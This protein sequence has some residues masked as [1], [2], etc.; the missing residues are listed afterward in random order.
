[1]HPPHKN[2]RVKNNAAFSL[3]ELLT[4][5]ALIG[6]AAAMAI[7][8]IGKIAGAAESSTAKRNA[9]QV[10][11]LSHILASLG[12][13]HVVPVSLGGKEATCRII[14]TGIVVSEGPMEGEFI[15]MPGLGDE[16]IPL[17]TVYLDILYESFS[18]LQLIFH[19]A[20]PDDDKK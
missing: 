10:A 9:Q 16:E 4:V 18:H 11:G 20:S 1:M 12:M 3:F 13:E 8:Q 5:I 15:G 2:P 17:A 6:I 7:P 19:A 14:K